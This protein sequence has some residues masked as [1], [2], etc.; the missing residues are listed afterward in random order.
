MTALARLWRE[1]RALVLAFCAAVLL[2]VFFAVRSALFWAHWSDP[3]RRDEPLA[4]WMTPRYVAL[5]WNVD[6]AV[7]GEALGL[8][9]GGGR[10]MTLAEIAAAQ[11]VPLSELEARLM[12]AI[13]AAR[14]AQ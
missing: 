1:R 10:R 4:G 6:R 12:A 8:E 13:E 3:A 5:S 2:A 11:G 9:P 14:T 7:V